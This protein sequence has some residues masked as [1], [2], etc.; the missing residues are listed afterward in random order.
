M[1]IRVLRA[2][3]KDGSVSEERKEVGQSWAVACVDD[4]DRK[5]EDLTLCELYNGGG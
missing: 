2:C 1:E 5:A 4:G 3:L